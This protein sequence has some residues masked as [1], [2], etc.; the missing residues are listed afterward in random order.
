VLVEMTLAVEHCCREAAECSA[1]LGEMALAEECRGSLS[2]VQAAESALAAAQVA[3]L[4]D[5]ALPK[6]ALAKEKWC[7]ED[8]AAEQR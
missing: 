5:L 6:P 3:V 4:A 8:A 1:A 7:Q 2:A